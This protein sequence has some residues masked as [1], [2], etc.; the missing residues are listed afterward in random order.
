MDHPSGYIINI[1]SRTGDFEI[2]HPDLGKQKR[3][4]TLSEF[5]D[6]LD[7]FKKNPDSLFPQQIKHVETP[8]SK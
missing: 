6:G 5:L 8:V 2:F 1:L 3:F 7:Q 4:S